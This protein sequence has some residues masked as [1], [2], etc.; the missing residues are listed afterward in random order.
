MMDG[1]FSSFFKLNDLAVTRVDGVFNNDWQGDY[2]RVVHGNNSW[3]EPFIGSGL[4][5][6]MPV[7]KENASILNELSEQDNRTGFIYCIVSDKFPILYVGI[8]EGDLRSGVFG[9]GRLQH[10][11][12]KLL[13]SA[14]GSTNHTKG[15]RGHASIRHKEYRSIIAAGEDVAWLEDIYISFAQADT[16]KQ[17]EGTVLDR[18]LERFNQQNVIADSFNRAKV[19]RAPAK[20]ELPENLNEILVRCRD[21]QKRSQAI[22]TEL[23]STDQNYDNLKSFANE[24]DEHLFGRLLQWARSYCSAEMFEG[25][26]EGYT[27]QPRG[28]NAKPVV[29][30]AEL[31]KAGKAMPHRWLC[32]IPLKTSPAHGMTVILPE[33]LMNKTLPQDQFERG[34]GT[35]FRPVDV[36]DFLANP[37]RYLA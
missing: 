26:V 7:L 32:R 34:K 37:G 15:W 3:S 23:H 33:R 2:H 6:G 19:S 5:V 22:G 17:I 20:I 13:A 30:F 11:I 12:R 4:T 21:A 35:N 25:I 9:P 8:S 18:F 16:P 14:G 10:H 24:S 27:N 36:T 1:F 29:R 31:G 28:Y